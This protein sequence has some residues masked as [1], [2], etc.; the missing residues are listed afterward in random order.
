MEQK[1]RAGVSFGDNRLDGTWI[2]RPFKP[3]MCL[4]CKYFEDVEKGTCPAYPE[5][6]PSR[7]ADMIIGANAPVQEKH[8]T[9]QKDQIGT[10]V[11]TSI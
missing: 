9:V 1:K 2:I 10:F 6:I 4:K 11:F 7:Y 8:S 3:S 5:G